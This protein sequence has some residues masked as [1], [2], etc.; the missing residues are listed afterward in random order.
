VVVR[1]IIF[2][3]S[4]TQVVFYQTLLHQKSVAGT[5]PATLEKLEYLNN[6]TK[7]K[8]AGKSA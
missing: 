3:A 7:A 5:M 8:H 6:R 2:R 4:F 1:Y